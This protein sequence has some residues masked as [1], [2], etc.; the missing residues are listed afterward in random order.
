MTFSTAPR[1]LA[2]KPSPGLG[3]A[4]FSSR[5]ILVAG[6]AENLIYHVL[7]VIRLRSEESRVAVSVHGA[8]ENECVSEREGEG[9]RELQRES[10]RVR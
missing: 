2:E 8:L 6:T 9:Q 7:V 3:R 1:V 5:P 10:E 4:L